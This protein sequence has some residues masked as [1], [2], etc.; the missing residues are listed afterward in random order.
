ML[1]S[2]KEDDDDDFVQTVAELEDDLDE[3]GN[4]LAD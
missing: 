1:A 3:A 4:V 2:N